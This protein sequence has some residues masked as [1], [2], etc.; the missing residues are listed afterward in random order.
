MYSYIVATLINVL[1][2]LLN[3]WLLIILHRQKVRKQLPWFV[4]YVAWEVLAGFALLIA[5]LI[6][7]QMYDALS[8]WMELVEIA[9]IVAAVRESFLRLFRGFTKKPGFLWSVWA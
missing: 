4:S 7:R 2:P 6:G 9:L 5:W 1:S 8:W 3:L